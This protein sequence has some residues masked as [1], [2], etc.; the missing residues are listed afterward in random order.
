VTA[1]MQ[2]RGDAVLINRVSR[3]M[4][5]RRLTIEDVAQGA[6]LNRRTVHDL[7]HDKSRRIDLET[8]NK[9][10]AYFDVDTQQVLEWQRA[11][12]DPAPFAAPATRRG[13]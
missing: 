2:R 12:D 3:L 1:T 7:Y 13:R 6:G 5:E 10:C 4:G 9:L 8:L 11:G